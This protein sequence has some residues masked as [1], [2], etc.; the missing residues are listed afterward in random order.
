M[1][2][3]VNESR[4]GAHAFRVDRPQPLRVGGALRHGHDLA[5]ADE[6]KEAEG[7]FREYAESKPP[8]VGSL[9]EL[10]KAKLAEKRKS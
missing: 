6:D 9:G 7:D 8:E 4:H 5:A 1:L 3:A 2:M 10:L